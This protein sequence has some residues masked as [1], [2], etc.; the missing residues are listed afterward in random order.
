MLRLVLPAQPARRQVEGE[1]PVVVRPHVGGAVRGRHRT[2]PAPQAHRHGRRPARLAGGRVQRRQPGAAE[3]AQRPVGG[4]Q[5]A[6]RHVHPPAPPQH[7]ATGRVQ[8]ED[9]RTARP[10]TGLRDVHHAP[11]DDGSA[12]GAP[13]GRLRPAPLTA[14]RVERQQPGPLA[15][16]E[17]GVTGQRQPPRDARVAAPAQRTVGRVVAVQRTPVH[18]VH[19]ATAD[20]RVLLPRGRGPVR[21]RH[22]PPQVSRGRVQDLDAGLDAGL[23]DHAHHAVPRGQRPP[24]GVGQLPPG[25]AAVRVGSADLPAPQHRAAARV[26]RAHAA[27]VPRG[28]QPLPRPGGQD[29][30]PAQ[31]GRAPQPGAAR[32]VPARPPAGPAADRERAEAARGAQQQPP[33]VD[34][35]RRRG[36]R[37]HCGCC[38]HRGLRGFGVHL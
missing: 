12:V 29:D 19:A 34:P 28:V 32:G 15:G 13:D 3:Q 17:H 30:P 37:G 7:L 24:A 6:L 31:G 8:G 10:L 26:D 27:V 38:G 9:R 14:A 20:G 18:R 1:Q 35:R 16:G 21:Q 36:C 33:A 11:L 22:L 25:R 5:R 4:R 2:R 23:G